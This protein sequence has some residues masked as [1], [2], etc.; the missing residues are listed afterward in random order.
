MDVSETVAQVYP[1][2]LPAIAIRDVVLFPHMA[3]PLSVDRP[4]SVAAIDTALK[5][6]KFMLALAQRKP[7]VND[8]EPGDLYAYGVL[9]EVAQSLRMPDGTMRVFLE[10]R[11]RARVLKLELDKEKACLMAEVEYPE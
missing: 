5:S 8:P 6:G 4:K 10:G 2:T 7:S 3:L 11:K 1:K 9:S